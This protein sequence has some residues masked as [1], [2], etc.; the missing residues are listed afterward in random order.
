MKFLKKALRIGL[1][2]GF[3]IA[4]WAIASW[5][6]AKPLLLP[7]PYRVLLALLEELK[8]PQFYSTTLLSLWNVMLGILI[9][10]LGGTLLACMTSYVRILRELLLPV[11]SV[12]KATP[13]ASFIV[14]ALIWIGSS[15]VPTLI[16]VLIVLPVVWTNLD[17]GFQRIDRGLS[18]LARVYRMPL[19]KRLRLLIFPSLSP[20]FSSAVRTS[21]G[22]AW[23][24]GIAAEI[25]AM[26]R[27]TI[28]TMIGEAKQYIETPKM[29]AWTLTVILL[30]ILIECLFSFVFDRLSRQSKYT[31]KEEPAHA[32]A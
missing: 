21:T 7:S 12:I 23:K 19:G 32:D 3:W 27:G 11:M 16:T 6:V 13:V 1:V 28:G 29:F 2:L 4:V 17:V 10:V 22:L 15:Y 18:E 14:L 9:A 26:P 20:Y 31:A 5:I 25:I 30:S 24:A 8:T